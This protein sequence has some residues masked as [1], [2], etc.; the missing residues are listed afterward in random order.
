V[1][2][3]RR[4]DGRD[5]GELPA[6]PG[7]FGTPLSIKIESFRN[8]GPLRTSGTFV[9]LD[10]V[11]PPALAGTSA[12][13]IY[14]YA[15]SYSPAAGFSATLLSTHTPPLNTQP[16]TALPN[17]TVYPGSIALLPG[18]GL[19]MTDNFTGALW[20]SDASYDL[21]SMALIDPRLGFGPGDDVVGI[22]RAQGGGTR[23]YTLRVPG[24]PG[25]PPIYPGVH[26]VTYAAIT[27]EVAFVRTATPGGIYAISR[28]ALLDAS[29]PPFFKGA[30]MREVVAPTVGL[31][32]LTDGLDYDRFHPTSP[33]LYWQRAPSDVAGGGF[34]TL[35]RVNLQTGAVQTVAK[36]N[37]VFDWANEISVLPSPFGVLD[38][39]L[40]LTWIVSSVGQEHNNP[41][42]NVLLGGVPTYVNPSLMPVTIIDRR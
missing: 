16:P 25:G 29:V 27:D 17:G 11:V 38:D 8:Q 6:P 32:D 41:D 26:S 28:T 34:N 2:I 23:P 12:V 5:L 22:A 36:S 21:W 20:V 40:P 39:V 10:N 35:R 1:H 19:V 24:P 42:V 15:Y 18:G 37:E 13:K 9:L 3:A 33:W 4:A 14:R 30:A 7:G 31:S